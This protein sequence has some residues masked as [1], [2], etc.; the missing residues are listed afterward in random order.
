MSEITRGSSP[1]TP[2]EAKQLWTQLRTALVTYQ[3]AMTTPGD[4]LTIEAPRVS[5]D[6]VAPYVQLIGDDGTI[7][8][9]ISGDRVLHPLQHMDPA[10]GEFL[11]VNGWTAPDGSDPCWRIEAP[12][13]LAEHTAEEVVET[14]CGGF[15]VPH[16]S[17]L[18]CAA[19]GPSA[20]LRHLLHLAE[21]EPPTG[22]PADFAESAA[23]RVA[24]QRVIDT[25]GSLDLIALALA[26]FAGEG[27]PETVIDG[28]GDLVV[29]DEHGPIYVSV[30]PDEA[31]L[32]VWALVVPEVAARRQAARELAA[33]NDRAL[34]SRWT[35]HSRQVLQSAKLGADPFVP[36]H[37]RALVAAFAAERAATVADLR[38]RLQKEY[39]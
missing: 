27:D 14:L 29:G 15:A 33:L 37:L 35:M 1:T 8:A 25:E 17:M 36:H 2:D 4:L 38:L 5:D 20:V 39:R 24:T 28:D 19:Q 6:H 9:R 18:T 31:V 3:S 32:M 21:G 7:H 34:W 22:G 10:L 12:I 23:R 26:C 11:D 16:P 30:H 13:A